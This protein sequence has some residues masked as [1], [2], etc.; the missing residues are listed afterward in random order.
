MI[1]LNYDNPKTTLRQSK[2]VIGVFLGVVIGN[3]CCKI[4]TKKSID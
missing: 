1:N 3:I 2:I 4:V